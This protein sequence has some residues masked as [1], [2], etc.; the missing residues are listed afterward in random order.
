MTLL[1]EASPMRHGGK[2]GRLCKMLEKC[3][4]SF[5]NLLLSS[6]VSPGILSYQFNGVNALQYL[7]SNVHNFS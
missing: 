3:L 7:V 2:D 5:K 1:N 4:S 6:I